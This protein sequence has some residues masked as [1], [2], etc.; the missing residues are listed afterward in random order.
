MKYLLKKNTHTTNLT[1][2]T[3]AEQVMAVEGQVKPT[4]DGGGAVKSAA[5]ISSINP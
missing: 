5:E 2:G 1:A 3:D 4:A